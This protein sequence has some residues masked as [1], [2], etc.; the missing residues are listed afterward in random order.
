MTFT[1]PAMQIQSVWKKFALGPV[2]HMSLISHC[3]ECEILK[4]RRNLT[5]GSAECA[6]VLWG[7][8]QQSEGLT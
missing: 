7:R 8:V 6:K 1:H 4:A 2:P 3:R 5:R